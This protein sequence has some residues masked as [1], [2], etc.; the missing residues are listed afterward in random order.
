M[1]YRLYK[2]EDFESGK[3][4]GGQMK[5]LSIYPEDA[6]YIDRNFIWRLSS[7]TVE[8]EDVYF[9]LLPDYDR[10]LLVLEGDVVL[11]Y[12]GER[13][14]RLKAMEQDRF[15]GNYRTKCFGQMKTYNLMVRKGAQGLLDVLT[16]SKEKMFPETEFSEDYQYTSQGFYCRSGYAVV[17]FGGETHMIGEGELFVLC[18]DSS[19]PVSVGIM[20]EGTVIRSQV[21]YDDMSLGPKVIEPERATLEDLKEAAKISM[22]NFEGSK[23]IFRYLK[24]IWYDEELKKGIKKLERFYIPALLWFIG[25]A[26]ILFLAAEVYASETVLLLIGIWSL[27]MFLLISPLLYFIVLPKP[28]KAHIKKLEE[29][30]DYEKGLV[31]KEMAANPKADKILKRYKISGRNTYLPDK[32]KKKKKK[33]R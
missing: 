4:S 27:I 25:L 21:F 1:N 31:E 29:L 11:V 3:W 12:E 5:E 14:A 15:D 33:S 7:D 19:E 16:L 23:Y 28:I 32:P 6:G 13:V 10:T 20:G 2:T 17:R 8:K 22:T 26:S 24:G 9:A 30:S 18:Y